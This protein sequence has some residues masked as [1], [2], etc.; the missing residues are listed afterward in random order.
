MFQIIH[1]GQNR[2]FVPR[3]CVA[4]VLKCDTGIVLLVLCCVVLVLSCILQ[5]LFRTTIVLMI[6]LRLVRFLL[7]LSTDLFTRT[8]FQQFG[9]SLSTS[10]HRPRP[11]HCWIRFHESSPRYESAREALLWIPQ[12]HD[13]IVSTHNNVC[14]CDIRNL[15]QQFYCRPIEKAK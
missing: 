8:I 6:L 1:S 12:I 13:S 14:L 5:C 11:R 2:Y 3:Q 10:H 15:L 4:L 7:E 9:I